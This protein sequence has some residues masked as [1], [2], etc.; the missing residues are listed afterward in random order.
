[1]NIFDIIGPVMIGPSSSHTAG[2]A[3][4]GRVSAKILGETVKTAKIALSGSFAETGEGHGTDKAIIAGLLGMTPDDERIPNS[5]DFAKKAGLEFKFEK[6]SIPRSHP[7]TALLNLEG[8]KGKS[9]TVQGASIGGGNIIITAVNGME[10]SF[11]GSEDTLIIAH[12]DMPGLIASV[13]SILNDFRIN[14]G[15]FRLNRTR[16]GSL[17]VMIV[18]IDGTMNDDALLILKKLPHISSVV[19]LKA[20]V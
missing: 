16:K 12:E 1:M 7:N 14:I 4:I 15:N 19:Y 6:V 2:A 8:E 3:R 9:C 17:A 10:T 13:T 11:S 5:F 18:E 20:I